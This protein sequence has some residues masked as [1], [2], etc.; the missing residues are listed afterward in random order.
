MKLRE[1]LINAGI[2]FDFFAKKIGVPKSTLNRIMKPGYV[3]S[4]ELVYI[5]EIATHKGVKYKDWVDGLNE[6]RTKSILKES[7]EENMKKDQDV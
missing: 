4:V 1:Y 3:P 7:V 5:I 2:R 6:R